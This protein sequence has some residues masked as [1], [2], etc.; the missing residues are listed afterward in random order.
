MLELNVNIWHLSFLR[1]TT[2]YVLVI[3]KSS[4]RCQ[5]RTSSRK[6]TS[7]PKGTGFLYTI[8]VYYSDLRYLTSRAETCGDKSKRAALN[9]VGSALLLR[10]GNLLPDELAEFL[11]AVR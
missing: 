4:R 1:C 9:A 5:P 8:G 10:A 7:Q 6:G 11:L 2:W 3:R